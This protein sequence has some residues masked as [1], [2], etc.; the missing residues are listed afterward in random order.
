LLYNAETSNDS[1]VGAEEC[2]TKSRTD[3]E[4]DSDKEARTAAW[5]DRDQRT[6][7]VWRDSDTD[8]KTRTEK[9]RRYSPA[10]HL[11]SIGKLLYKYCIVCIVIRKEKIL[12]LDPEYLV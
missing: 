9:A 8:G 7:A 1:G 5:Q 6:A 3:F 10:E 4:K 2:E 11:S 12:L